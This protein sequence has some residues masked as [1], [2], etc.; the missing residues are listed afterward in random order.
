MVN[1]KTPENYALLSES[2]T[3]IPENHTKMV[4]NNDALIV[5]YNKITA[6]NVEKSLGRKIIMNC[7]PD[8]LRLAALPG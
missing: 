7:L 2:N 4:L 1:G 5:K 8:W 6:K 3:I